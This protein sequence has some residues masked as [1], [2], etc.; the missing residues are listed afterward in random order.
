M[1]FCSV[2]PVALKTRYELKRF[3]IEPTYVFNLANNRSCY[4]QSNALNKST[5]K[6][7]HSPLLSRFSFNFLNIAT[8]E[9]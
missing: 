9:F 1:N 8:D 5:S 7:P 6:A 4:R 2:F 3:V